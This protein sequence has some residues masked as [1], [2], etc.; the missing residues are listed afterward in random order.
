MVYW[1]NFKYLIQLNNNEESLY[2]LTFQVTKDCNCNCT[3]C[4]ETNKEKIYMTE[5]TGKECIDFF[6]K[7]FLYSK[8]KIVGL[9]FIGGEPLLNLDV[10]DGICSYFIKQCCKYQKDDWLKFCNFSFITNGTLCNT[11][12]FNK[13]L[14]KYKDFLFFT[15]TLDGPQSVHDLCRKYKNGNGTFNDVFTNWS[16]LFK[17]YPECVKAETKVT[18]SP[19]NVHQ[20]FNIIIFFIQNNFKDININPTF[21]HKW[22]YQ[23][24]FIYYQQLKKAIDFIIEQKI[25]NIDFECLRT[26]KFLNENKSLCGSFYNKSLTFDVNG[27]IFSCIR[28]TDIVDSDQEQYCLGHI[29]D[30]QIKFKSF[31]NYQ[32]AFLQERNPK[33]ISCPIS[34]G[35]KFCP[36]Y[37]YLQNGKLFFDNTNL[38]LMHKVEYLISIYYQKKKFNINIEN[39]LSK[40]ETI[41]IVSKEVFNEIYST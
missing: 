18:I 37:N 12:K 1:D 5:K 40:E 13:F 28:F 9:N 7:N 11:Q 24:A 15:I 31:L 16:Q 26:D 23:E 19:D 6:F 20:V 10:I 25:E 3:Y 36:A 17:K 22:G 32:D 29:Q 34:S 41:K 2:T 35:C 39:Q 33:C 27:N 21:E 14:E 38:C 4:Y 30:E 8:I